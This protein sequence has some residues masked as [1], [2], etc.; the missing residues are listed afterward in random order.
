MSLDLTTI[1]PHPPEQLG[2]IELLSIALGRNS[3]AA[4]TLLDRFGGL[5]GLSRAAL[6]DLIDARVPLRRAIQLYAALEL[7]RR[8]LSEPLH[9][10]T[11]LTDACHAEQWLHARLAHREQEELHVLGLDVRHRVL[12]EFVAAVGSVSEVHVDPRNV[13]RRLVRE[14]ASA[15]IV[16]HNHP[17]GAAEP[18]DSDVELTRKLAAAGA[19]V[20]ITVLDHVIVARAGAFSFARHGVSFITDATFCRAE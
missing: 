8:T 6:P 13:F 4:A 10:G 2:D 9:R 16:A 7:G 15:A 17:S 19:V 5:H 20:G 3:A 11:A 14:N 12:V 1:A 18:S